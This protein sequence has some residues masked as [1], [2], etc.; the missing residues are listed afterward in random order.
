MYVGDRWEKPDALRQGDYIYLPMSFNGNVP[1]IDDYYQDWD[2]NLEEGT[3]RPF[4]Y[5]KNLALN[6]TATAS[7]VNGS[8]TA[9]NAIVSSTYMNFT[10]KRWESAA[11]DP[12]WIRVDLGS[13]MDVNRVILKWHENAGKSFKIQVSNDASTWNDVYSTEKGGSRTVTD[14]TFDRTKARYV[15]MNG[16]RRTGSKGYSLFDFMILND[17]DVTSTMNYRSTSASKPS[18]NWNNSLVSYYLPLPSRIKLEVFDFS[19]KSIGVLVNG[20]QNAG[21]HNVAF[22]ETRAAGLYLIRLQDGV[23]NHVSTRIIGTKN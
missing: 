2:F 5:S 12:Q 8:N 14:V 7:S 18:L 3:W 15:R 13:A 6:K 19:G 20:Y 11:S 9:G 1:V 17:S 4:D 23:N 16:T 22:P 21:N 10:D